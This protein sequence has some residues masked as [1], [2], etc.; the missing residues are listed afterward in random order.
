MCDATRRLHC[1]FSILAANGENA[2]QAAPRLQDR[3]FRRMG[4]FHM[5][6]PDI[7]GAYLQSRVAKYTRV[8]R[9]F[10]TDKE[11]LQGGCFG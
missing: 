9:G 10:V 1:S 11:H 7:T 4:T 6:S 8:T 2:L 3:T 5:R